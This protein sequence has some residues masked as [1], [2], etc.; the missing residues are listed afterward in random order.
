MHLIASSKIKKE[1][2]AYKK[3][4]AFKKGALNNPSLRYYVLNW[5]GGGGE[6]EH[7][8]IPLNDVYIP[9]NDVDSIAH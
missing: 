3:V 2:C 7:R 4:C 5:G 1:V 6:G 8:R 9:L